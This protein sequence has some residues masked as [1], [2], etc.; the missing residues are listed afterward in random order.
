MYLMTWLRQSFTLTSDQYRTSVKNGFFFDYHIALRIDSA[1]G[2]T[3]SSKLWSK[4]TSGD[5]NPVERMTKGA[6]R[7][8]AWKI[9]PATEVNLVRSRHLLKLPLTAYTCSS[10][11]RSK[12][13]CPSRASRLLLISSELVPLLRRESCDIKR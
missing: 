6:P 4:S 11:R 8:S 9:W 2:H 7:S 12:I 5:V 10:A 1:Q 3:S 13:S